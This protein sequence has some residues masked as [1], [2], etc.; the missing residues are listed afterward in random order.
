MSN[1]YKQILDFGSNSEINNP[2]TYCMNINMNHKF[3]HGSSS[4]DYGQ[5]SVHCQNFLSDYCS[6][7][8][9][10]FC[11]IASEETKLLDS[12]G[13]T[14]GETLIKDTAEKKY[15]V[16]VLG[17]KKIQRPFDPNVAASPL[18][19]YWVSKEDESLL[20]SENN[21]IGTPVYDIDI[22]NID[23]DIVIKYLV[24]KPYIAPRVLIGLYKS[25]KKK[26]AISK[27]SDTN[28]G[29]FYVKNSNIF[30]KL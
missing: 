4:N 28:L 30:N 17:C 13:L 9:D 24:E 12:N 8:W 2:L 18:I 19:T 23:N 7:K 20:H 26:N 10:D 1:N 5:H 6:E 16:D 22:N 14:A 11:Q 25:I 15:I 29:N 3:L 27:I 21:N